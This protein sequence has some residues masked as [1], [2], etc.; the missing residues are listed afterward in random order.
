MSGAFGLVGRGTWG[1]CG[2]LIFLALL[3]MAGA[4]CSHV[5]PKSSKIEEQFDLICNSTGRALNRSGETEV[6]SDKYVSALNWVRNFRYA[7][8]VTTS[9]FDMVDPPPGAPNQPDKIVR[10]AGTEI[11]FIEDRNIFET[12]DYSTG[13]YFRIEAEDGVLSGVVKGVCSRADFSGFPDAPVVKR[14][15]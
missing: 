1:A 5:K 3:A 15:G 2:T 6:Q 4:S 11:T 7:V 9:Q 14:P 12:Y 10:I 13:A 8:N